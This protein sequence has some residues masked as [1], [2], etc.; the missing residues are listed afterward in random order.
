MLD[1]PVCESSSVWLDVRQARVREADATLKMSV[2]R[3]VVCMCV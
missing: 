3:G 2:V 1:A